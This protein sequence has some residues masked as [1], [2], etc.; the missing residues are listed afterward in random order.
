VTLLNEMRSFPKVKKIMDE[1]KL[2][3]DPNPL[4]VKG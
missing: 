1:W 3:I 4:K 2:E